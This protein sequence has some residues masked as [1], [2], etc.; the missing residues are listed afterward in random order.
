M[1]MNP[2]DRQAPVQGIKHIVAVG[3]GKGGVGK[4]T[5][6][7]NLAL[8]LKEN[9]QKVGLLDADIY[10]PSVPRMFGALNQAPSVGEDRKIQPLRRHGLSLMSMG[11]LVDENSGVVWRGPMLFKA[12]DQ[13]LRDVAWGELDFL[14]VDLPPGTGDVALTLAQKV[15]LTGAVVVCTP[16]NMA[17]AD[18]KR[19]VDM[20]SRINVPL[21]GVIENMAYFKPSPD[22]DPV[23]LFPRGDLDAY[24]DA[25]KIK[26]LG[27]IPFRPAIGVA[28]EAGVPS[29]VAEPQAEEAEVFRRIAIELCG[30]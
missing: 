24:L 14:I 10:G 1:S 18:A 16:Q 8:A 27:R 4:S 3:S 2:F 21:L 26:K 13:F 30:L 23:D 29:F 19:A 9:G 15:P 7:A 5:V 11:F 6:A 12:M 28:C 17:L 22:S 25:R 20:F